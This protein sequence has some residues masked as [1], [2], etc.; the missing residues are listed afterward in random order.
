MPSARSLRSGD[1]FGRLVVLGL[2][3]VRLHNTRA[4]D[5]VCDCG[6]RKTARAGDLRHGTI[7][8]CGCLH[9]EQ[10]PNVTSG[11]DVSLV[12]DEYNIWKG[13]KR[14]CHGES[15]QKTKDYGDRGISIC[16][17]WRESFLAF[18]GD[19]GLRPDDSRSVDRIDN[20]G[21]YD[22]G[23]CS[24]CFARGIARSNCRWATR[25][26]QANNTRSNR[27]IE[28]RGET[29][30][31]AEWERITGIDRFAIYGRLNHGWSPEK[32]LTTPTRRTA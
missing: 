12:S 1:R 28:L 10:R 6:G 4:W 19:M 27:R 29:H 21:G 15:R 2:S 16:A 31:I 8:S 23:R 24:D 17:R 22:C 26:E 11:L 32:A 13:I 25:E 5:C 7:R 3:V 30:S 20:N 14:R 9:A 18:L